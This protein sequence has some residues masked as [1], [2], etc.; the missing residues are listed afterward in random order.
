MATL[1]KLGRPTWG[2]LLAVLVVHS[3]LWIAVHIEV[4]M[5][6]L[7]LVLAAWCVFLSGKPWA[8]GPVGLSLIGLLT[9]LAGATHQLTFVV[10]A[11][12]FFSLLWLQRG[13][14][15]IDACRAYLT[16]YSSVAE[17]SALRFAQAYERVVPVGAGL[18]LKA[19]TVPR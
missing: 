18:L 15:L 9:G 19:S 3:V 4:Y 5:L 13:H 16:G 12:V 7:V 1:I 8:R 6:H 2:A 10:L 14:S 11:P 17:N